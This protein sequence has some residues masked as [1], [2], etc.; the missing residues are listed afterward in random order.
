MKHCKAVLVLLV[1]ALS[2]VFAAIGG[3]PARADDFTL[4]PLALISSPDPLSTSGSAKEWNHSTVDTEAIACVAVNPTNPNNIVAHWNAHDWAGTVVSVTLDGGT[5]WN[6]VPFPGVSQPTGGIYPEAAWPWLSFAPNGML[7]ASCEGT[8]GNPDLVFVS[9][10][11]NGGLTWNPPIA[12]GIGDEGTKPSLTA[13]PANAKYAYMVWS[14]GI[15]GGAASTQFSRTTDGGRT[16][17]AARSIYNAPAGN[18]VWGHQ[19]EVLPNGTLVCVFTELILTGVSNNIPQYNYALSVQQST[20][21]GRTWSVPSKVAAQL[22]RTDPNPNDLPWW[23][24]M[25]DPE[26]GK[27]IYSPPMAP[28][29]AMDARN[30]NLYA[31]WIDARFNGG[32]YNSI[33]FS[34]STDGGFSW[35]APIQVNQTPT[36]IPLANQQAWNPSVA[37]SANG[38]IGVSYYDLRNNTPKKSCLADYWLVHCRPTSAKP[39]TDPANWRHE[40]RISDASFNLRKAARVNIGGSNAYFVG[41]YEGLTA[42]GDSFAAVWT[43][44][45]A[46]SPDH[47]LFRRVGP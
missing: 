1:S 8:N 39:A 46:D 15:I 30:G 36:N 34:Q 21:H 47:I 45:F 27:G 4:D 35:S 37:V 2:Y 10:S 29:V 22:P 28:S 7:Y 19:I 38:T 14:L 11:S 3:S 16:W 25:T 20:N 24:T 42:V 41:D 44:P 13:D 26:N 18:A 12:L 6:I 40:T 17:E 43:Q 33:A 5:T 31:V 23:G 9:Q 32:Q